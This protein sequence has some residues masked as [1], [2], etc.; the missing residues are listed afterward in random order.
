[1]RMETSTSMTQSS[2][3][4]TPTVRRSK[5][6]TA[7]DSS[8][9]PLMLCPFLVQSIF[10]ALLF[11]LFH[12]S[13]WWLFS[14]GHSHLCRFLSVLSYGIFHCSRTDPRAATVTM[15]ERNTLKALST[16]G[17]RLGSVERSLPSP[18][19]L[20]NSLEFNHWR[21]IFPAPKY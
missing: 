13:R 19:A 21:L 15:I 18:N 11:P 4:G 17:P 16:L 10:S 7:L 14:V 6:R 5:Q 2:T 8:K 20:T 1:M 9:R 3:Y 12:R